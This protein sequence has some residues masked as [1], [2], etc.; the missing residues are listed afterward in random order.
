MKNFLFGV[1][2]IMMGAFT[3]KAQTYYGSIDRFTV[4]SG[5]NV[6][7]G[8]SSTTINFTV[9]VNRELYATG[10]WNWKPFNMNFKVG[11][12][13]APG[14]ALIEYLSPV[15]NVSSSNFEQYDSNYEATFSFS[16]PS[17]KLLDD[18]HLVLFYNIPNAGSTNYNQFSSYFAQINNP[19]PGPVFDPAHIS[20]I[21]S[22]GFSTN[23][24]QSFNNDYYLVDGDVLIKKDGLNNANYNSYVISGSNDHNV[25]ILIDN[26][27]WSNYT[28][29]AALQEAL[30]VWNSVPNSNI[31]I[32]LISSPDGYY[33]ATPRTD[34]ILKGDNGLLPTGVA[35]YAA[36]PK[37]D[38]NPGDLIVVNSDF[39]QNSQQSTWNMI[40]AIGHALGLK[41]AVNNSSSVMNKGNF[42]TSYPS[43]L[44]FALPTSYDI[45]SITSLYPLNLNSTILPYIHGRNGTFSLSYYSVESG[46]N[47]SWKIEGTNGTN[48]TYE[49]SGA[50]IVSELYL[51]PGNYRVQCIISNGKYSIPVTVSKNIIL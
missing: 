49:E 23:G 46:I 36:Y 4:N 31:K 14:T 48:Y 11:L 50:A 2:F 25:N 45:N 10:N 6:V 15:Y 44:N 7:P 41:H 33:G 38:G 22:M 39:N 43:N 17:S 51:S 24:I 12:V 27:I 16:V 1:L 21:Q 32:N 34:I 9:K 13:L 29:Y 28:W 35:T 42:L 3:V 30:K 47:Y 40:H 5:W 26:S 37:G 8:S 20:K 18:Y 19:P